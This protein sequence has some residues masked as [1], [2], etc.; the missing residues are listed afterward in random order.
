MISLAAGIDY[1]GERVDFADGFDLAA[2][3]FD[4]QGEVFVRRI[5]FDHVA[6]HAERAAAQIFG[7]VVLNFDQLAQN[8]FARDGLALFEHQ[9]HAVIG[10]GRAE[11]VDAGDRSDDDHVAALEERARGAHAQLVELVVDRGFFFDVGVAG[12]DVGFGLV[13][14]VVADEV[15]DGVLREER[16]ELVEELRGQRFIVR[17]D[18]GRAVGGLD[19]LGHGEGFAGAGDAEQ[20]LVAVAVVHAADELGDGLG[21]VAAGFVVAGKLEFHGA[22]L[23]HGKCGVVNLPL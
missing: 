13:V 10:L 20:D 15:F 14:I 8:R 1:A 19:H 21:L 2:P 22:H 5:D 17:E 23:R 6:A 3:H 11:A 12:G 9:H 18:D 7:A 16:L 4:A